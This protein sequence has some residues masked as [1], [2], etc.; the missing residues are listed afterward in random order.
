MGDGSDRQATG[1][2]APFDAIRHE[3][4]DEGEFWSAR[5]LAKALGYTEFGKFRNAIRRAESACE[6]SNHAV[7]DHFA[8][9]SDMIVAGKGAQR[10][11]EDVHLSRYACYLIVQ[12]ADPEKPIVAL[13]QTY[14][15]TQTRR[16]ELAD[17]ASLSEA[18]KRLA[19]REQVAERN[20]AL[21]VT[22]QT[23]G[24]VTAR[25]FAIFQDHGYMGLYAGER[26]RDIHARKGLKR[27]QHILDH[28]GSTELAANWFRATQADDKIK[29]EGIQG[30]DAANQTHYAVGKA[31]R[32]FIVEDLGGD[33]PEQLPTPA[34]SAQQLQR[35]EQ[36]RIEADER[37]RRQPALFAPDGSP[38][39]QA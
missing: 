25:D 17:I 19:L 20:T 8:H 35:E 2:V 36:R 16:Q 9:V 18:Q 15:A 13:G 10:Q 11:V 26:A 30:R 12:N 29:R 7:S 31:V 5:E 22:A 21:A 32:R 14:F 28:M 24:V 38:D 34:Q 6:S 4:D 27:G 23:A 37:Q 39:E 33:A 3:S 1:P